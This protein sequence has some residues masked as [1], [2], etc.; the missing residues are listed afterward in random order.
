MKKKD[1]IVL[2]YA[3]NNC[4]VQVKRVDK[5]E[6]ESF[7]LDLER[8]VWSFL[9][10]KDVP[11][12]EQRS[13]YGRGAFSHKYKHGIIGVYS[14]KDVRHLDSMVHDAAEAVRPESSAF[15]D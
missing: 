4:Y 2:Q 6:E 5:I 1:L 15:D 10:W 13:P 11:I 8:K 7:S 14:S 9:C 3:S 12:G